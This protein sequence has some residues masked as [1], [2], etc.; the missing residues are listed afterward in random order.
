MGVNNGT[1][2]QTE[3]FLQGFFQ[4]K[5]PSCKTIIIIQA[6]SI[7]ANYE[8]TSWNVTREQDIHI[9]CRQIEY[10]SICFNTCRLSRFLSG[11][12]GAYAIFIYIFIS[13]CYHK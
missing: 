4:K 5:R 12:C 7:R 3:N 9:E 10:G 1:Q 2:K 8:C 6:F 13:A 11:I